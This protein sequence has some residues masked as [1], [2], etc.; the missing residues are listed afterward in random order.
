MT[1]KNDDAD[2]SADE[3]SPAGDGPADALADQTSS[4]DTGGDDTGGDDTGGAAASD[5]DGAESP[6]DRGADATEVISRDGLSEST[7]V[8]SGS[9]D[10]T[11]PVEV[12]AGSVDLTKAVDT[13]GVSS[14]DADG[15][16]ATSVIATAAAD[17]DGVADSGDDDESGTDESG[18]D[19]SGAA[20]S[21]TEESGTAGKP[22]DAGGRRKGVVALVQAVSV[23]L[24]AAA[25]AFVGYFGYVAVREQFVYRPIAELRDQA[26]DKAEK[27]M[28]YALSVDPAKMDEWNAR[29]RSVMVGDALDQMTAQI[30][31][32]NEQINAQ[33]DS[34]VSLHVTEVGAAPI[35]LDENSNSVRVLVF[36][37][38]SPWFDGKAVTDTTGVAIAQPMNFEVTVTKRGGD[39]MVSDVTP[40]LDYGADPDGSGMT[41]D[42]SQM[43]SELDNLPGGDAES[44]PAEDEQEGGN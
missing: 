35:F 38:V 19:E 1:S 32:L 37:T 24:L 30:E 27:A 40:L 11:K 29:V 16:S 4:D 20:E 18:T 15:D 39:L 12:A 44:T 6:A 8:R 36:V 5:A 25:I 41:G 9:V 2:H 13:A 7:E 28:V 26:T 14:A 42:E 23:A 21:G 22:N 3:A 33:A 17:G 43:Q 34:G 10:L 31:Q